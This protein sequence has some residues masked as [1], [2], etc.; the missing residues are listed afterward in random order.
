MNL[1]TLHQNNFLRRAYR[2]CKLHLVSNWML[3]IFPYIRKHNSIVTRAKRTE[4][5]SLGMEI[6]DGDNYPL[7]LLPDKIQSVA[8]I[9]CNVG[10]F[11][12]MLAS[13]YG[14]NL[15]GIMVDA[16]PE[17]IK[18]A[19]WHCA[20]NQL[21]GIEV[22]EGIVG[23]KSDEFYVFEA[24]TCSASRLGEQQTAD[25]KRFTKTHGRLIDFESEC[26]SMWKNTRCDVLKVDIEGAELEFLRSCPTF[27]GLVDNA[28]IEWH[29]QY[30]VSLQ[31][32][33][34]IM[35]SAGLMYVKTISKTG[36][37]GTAFYK[38]KSK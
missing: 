18:E 11:T 36:T 20:E 4:H 27:L 29:E 9:G 23:S 19:R 38:R 13:K 35:E 10:Y 37:N 3:G 33:N 2:G 6:F 8:D 31:D 17:V 34:T 25:L 32:V 26:R 22:V 14:K 30:D 16:N 28:F 24:D 1:V 15:R 21:S 12:C 5:V 7:D